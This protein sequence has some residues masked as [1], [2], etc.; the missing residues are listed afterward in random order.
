[1]K[2]PAD[3]LASDLR[4]VAGTIP[5]GWRAAVLMAVLIILFPL[6]VTVLIFDALTYD[7]PMIRVP[8]RNIAHWATAWR[9]LT[10]RR[11]VR[12]ARAPRVRHAH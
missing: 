10:P 7:M 4:R 6:L 5:V 11:P 12:L 1:M 8:L 2:T 9:H 3:M